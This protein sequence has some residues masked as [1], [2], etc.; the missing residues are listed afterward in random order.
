V[1]YTKS[2]GRRFLEAYFKITIEV[3]YGGVSKLH[4][5]SNNL[6]VVLVK[7]VI[8]KDFSW[9]R[10]VLRHVDPDQWVVTGRSSMT[11]LG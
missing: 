2:I 1:A 11:H 4:E 9:K 10:L 6:A 7:A 5:A 8:N 3:R